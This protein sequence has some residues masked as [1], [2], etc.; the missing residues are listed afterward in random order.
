MLSRFGTEVASDSE[1]KAPVGRFV[2]VELPGKAKF[3]S[4]AEVEVFSED[5]NVALGAQAEQSSTDYAGTAARAI[6]GKTDGRL[7]TRQLDHA[8]RG[9]GQ[10]VVGGPAARA[11]RDR[12]DQCLEP[13]RQG[14]RGPAVQVPRAGA[15]RRPQGRLADRGG[16]AA[17][18]AAAELS[19]A[20]PL[21]LAFARVRADFAQAGF[22]IAGIIDPKAAAAKSG[23]GVSPRQKERHEAVFVLSQPLA[24]PSPAP[25][26]LRLEHRSKVPGHNLGRFR[27]GVSSDP[28]AA[29]WAD[30][31]PAC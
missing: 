14:G 27:L 22:D 23:W 29:R 26:D 6:D 21:A 9:R 12:A 8:H 28:A 11:G 2:R 18:T 13:H 30:V 16:R 31:P 10:P 15:R 5:T 3:L 20:G 4:L 24:G 17:Q 1:A 25:F 19:T 7:L